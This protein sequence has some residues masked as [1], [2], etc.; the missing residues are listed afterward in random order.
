RRYDGQLKEIHYRTGWDTDLEVLKTPAGVSVSEKRLESQITTAV[1]QGSIQSSLFESVLN[2]KEHP[3]LAVRLSEIFAWYLDFYTDLQPGDTFR[4][5]FEKRVVPGDEVPAYGRIYAAE[6]VNGGK[7]F[8]AVLF[9]DPSGQPAY[10][11]AEGKS[12]QKA[13]LKS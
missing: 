10:Y 4:L 2:A 1:V 6:Y 13:F 11:T 7:V 9:R 12:L 5:V 8:S 3:E